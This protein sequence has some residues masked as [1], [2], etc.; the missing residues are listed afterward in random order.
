MPLVTVYI[1]KGLQPL[2]GYGYKYLIIK[3]LDITRSPVERLAMQSVSL[4]E[5]NSMAKKKL[6]ARPGA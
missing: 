5:K 6:R 3:R 1:A 2:L 4:A